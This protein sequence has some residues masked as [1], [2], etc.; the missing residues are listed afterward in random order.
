M[1][2]KYPFINALLYVYFMYIFIYLF[3]IYE[4]H[5]PQ[6]TYCNQTHGIVI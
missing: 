1:L 2:P 5:G 6:Y 4:F 3:F